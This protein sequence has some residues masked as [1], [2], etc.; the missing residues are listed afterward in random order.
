ME[1]LRSEADGPIR[2]YVNAAVI[3]YSFFMRSV[4][5]EKEN[6]MS[7]QFRGCL[8]REG[9]QLSEL[10]QGS[11]TSVAQLGLCTLQVVVISSRTLRAVKSQEPSVVH[12]CKNSSHLLCF[13]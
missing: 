10:I 13:S 3:R 7:W 1:N 8:G 5:P 6:F 4:S 2:F 12:M 9:L 11:G